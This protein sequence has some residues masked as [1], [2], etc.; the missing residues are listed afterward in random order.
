MNLQHKLII[1]TYKNNYE[2]NNVPINL[3]DG[4]LKSPLRQQSISIQ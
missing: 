3:F 1:K 2:K 4:H